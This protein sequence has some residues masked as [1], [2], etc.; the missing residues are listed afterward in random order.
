MNF[1]ILS[2][3]VLSVLLFIISFF[4]KDPYNK[5]REEMDEIAISQLQEMYQI[6]KKIKLLEEELLIS[7]ETVPSPISVPMQ[8]SDAP[9]REIHAII[10]NQVWS[11]L[12]QGLSVEQISTQAS[13]TKEEV[14]TILAEFAARGSYD[15]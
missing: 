7:E 3:L 9:K 12:Q 14:E 5:L 2:L 1:I 8:A 11:L 6:K 4:L 13:L 10:K 15:E